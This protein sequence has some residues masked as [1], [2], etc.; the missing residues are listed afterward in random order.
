M[1]LKAGFWIGNGYNLGINI[2]NYSDF[3]ESALRFR[4]EIGFG[5]GIFRIV[6]GYNLVLTNK[7]FTGINNHNFGLNVMIDLRKLK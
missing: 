1:G 5:F 4:P 6:Y 7:D 2:I 3:K